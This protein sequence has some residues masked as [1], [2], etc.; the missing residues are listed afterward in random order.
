MITPAILRARSLDDPGEVL[1]A[2]ISEGVV[3]QPAVL[4][5][6]SLNRSA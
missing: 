6:G 2:G 3:G 1:P 4:P 5:L